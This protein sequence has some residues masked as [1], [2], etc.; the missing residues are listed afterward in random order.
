MNKELYTIT[1]G[2]PDGELTRRFAWEEQHLSDQ[3]LL[4]GVLQ[5]ML[6]TLEKMNDHSVFDAE[7]NEDYAHD[8][9][10]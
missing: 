6:D 7:K 5:D 1:V 9:Q 2:T 8:N 3:D 10:I 4:G